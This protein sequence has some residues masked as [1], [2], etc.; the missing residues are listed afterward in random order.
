[1]RR[2]ALQTRLLG[3]RIAVRWP[4]LIALPGCWLF[5]HSALGGVLAFACVTVLLLTHE[6]GHAAVAR[7]CGLHVERIELHLLQGWCFY[8]GAEYEIQDVLVSWGGVIVQALLFVVFDLAYYAARSA[9]G[10]LPAALEPIFLVFLAWNF[11]SM[12][13]NLL[14]ANG[15]D[16]ER[17]WKIVPAIRDGSLTQYLRARRYALRIAQRRW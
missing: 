2:Y 7:F 5:T 11:L 8:S 9:F 12:I 6:F 17:A 1:M 3:T 14:P 15:L 10:P 13:L 16:G 4:F